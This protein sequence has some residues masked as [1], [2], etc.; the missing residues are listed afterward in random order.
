[1]PRRHHEASQRDPLAAVFA[2]PRVVDLPCPCIPPCLTAYFVGVLSPA[3]ALLTFPEAAGFLRDRDTFPDSSGEGPGVC[4]CTGS[5]L[6]MLLCPCPS[7]TLAHYPLLGEH[8]PSHM[9]GE[10]KH[11][12]LVRGADRVESGRKAFR[13][14]KQEGGT[15]VDASRTESVEHAHPGRISDFAMGS[16]A[17]SW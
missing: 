14:E 3:K 1:M 4:D 16:E 11:T 8:L 17:W 12:C 7:H 13:S 2:T 5:V 15:S 6:C 9:R 10:G